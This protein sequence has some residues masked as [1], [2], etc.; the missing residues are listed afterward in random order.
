MVSVIL[1]Q[2]E[3][4]WSIILGSHG[5]VSAE[6][7][8]LDSVGIVQLLELRDTIRVCFPSIVRLHSIVKVRLS[9]LL[10][11]REQS[12]LRLDQ[13]LW[14]RWLYYVP[15]ESIDVPYSISTTDLAQDLPDSSSSHTRSYV[16]EV[17]ESAWAAVAYLQD[18]VDSLIHRFPTSLGET[19]RRVMHTL[20]RI[21]LCPARGTD[22]ARSLL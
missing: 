15:W 12:E 5:R 1:I 4:T 9:T 19:R 21:Y 14:I 3:C 18:F 2:D 17:Y 7:T 13:D 8:C 22:H 16:E 6:H 20:Y 10:D 11:I